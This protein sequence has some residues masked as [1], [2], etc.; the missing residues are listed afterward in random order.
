MIR[1]PYEIVIYEADRL[2]NRM[3]LSTTIDMINYYRELYLDLIKTCGWTDQE[4]DEETLRRV[5][6]YWQQRIQCN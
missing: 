3:A 5:D 2:I 1:V 6:A 4:L